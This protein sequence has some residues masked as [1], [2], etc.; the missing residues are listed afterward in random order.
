MPWHKEQG[1]HLA[2]AAVMIDDS[3]S[4]AHQGNYHKLI[5]KSHVWSIWKYPFQ[6]KCSRINTI[7][8]QDH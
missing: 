6:V 4:S 5:F 8:D 2:L 1:K 7:S 3:S